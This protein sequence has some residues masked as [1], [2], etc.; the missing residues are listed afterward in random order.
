VWGGMEVA[1]SWP[2]GRGSM[3]R[4]LTVVGG[5]RN[6]TD[7]SV[8]DQCGLPAPG[9]QFT[10]TIRVG[11]REERSLPVLPASEGHR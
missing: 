4:T 3:A 10:L 7:A 6:A 9:R 11:G 1:R 8:Y 5:V 2:L